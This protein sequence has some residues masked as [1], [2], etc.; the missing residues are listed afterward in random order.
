MGAAYLKVLGL[1]IPRVNAITLRTRLA[2][3]LPPIDINRREEQTAV[4]GHVPGPVL[5]LHDSRGTRR[6]GGVGNGAVV[7][8]FIIPIGGEGVGD[9]GALGLDQAVGEGVVEALPFIS[10]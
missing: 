6:V 2:Q 7:G 3:Q 10:A 9:A 4:G 8:F 5:P 1:I